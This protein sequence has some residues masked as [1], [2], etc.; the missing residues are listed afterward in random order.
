MKKQY[1]KGWHN[2]QANCNIATTSGI[3]H[4]KNFKSKYQK[5]TDDFSDKEN[6]LLDGAYQGEWGANYITEEMKFS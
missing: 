1:K 2:G 5:C 3:P 4:H 6:N